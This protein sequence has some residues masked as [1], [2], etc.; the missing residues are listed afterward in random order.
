MAQPAEEDLA[1]LLRVLDSLG[2]HDF[3]FTGGLAFGVWVEP[4]ETRDLDLCA[5]LPEAAVLPLLAQYDGMRFGPSELPDIVRFRVRDWD[6]DLFVAKGPADAECLA[7][8][9]RV[10]IGALT[11]PVV[12]PEDLVVHKM[13]KLRS[14][15]RRLLQDAADLRA[16]CERR[17]DRMDWGYIGEHLSEADRSLLEAIRGLSDEALL[18]R[19]LARG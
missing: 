13:R 5:A 4:R 7:R 3:A 1:R 2:I 19:L 11:V 6:V 10:L 17:G 9:V 15:R 18:Q 12:T 14:D 16:L 8:A